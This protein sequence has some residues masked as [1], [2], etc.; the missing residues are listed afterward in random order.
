MTGHHAILGSDHLHFRDGDDNTKIKITATTNI[1]T[2]SGTGDTII[3]DGIGTPT[4]DN[5]VA[6]KSYVDSVAEGLN[7]LGAVK[8]ATTSNLNYTYDN[9][10]ATLTNG[11]TG[12]VSIDGIAL[13]LN[14]R[15]LVKDQTTAAQNG[16]YKVTT[17]GADA[18]GDNDAV[19]LVLTRSSDMTTGD[20]AASD[21]T[22]V[23]QG[24]VNFDAGFVCTS[25][26][27]SDTVGT[28][29]LTFTQFSGAGSI[30]AGT[31]LSKSGNTINLD[32]S[33]SLAGTLDVTGDT[34]VSTLDST[35]ATSLATGG[36]AVNIASSGAMTT[37]KGTLNVDEAVTLDSTLDVTGETKLANII[38]SDNHGGGVQRC[39]MKTGGQI[40]SQT[41]IKTD[42]LYIGDTVHP[43]LDKVDSD[44]YRV[45]IDGSG[46]IV[47]EGNLDVTGDTSVSTFDS[48]GATSLA[49]GGG[50]VNIAS[51]GVMTTVKGTL[52]VDEAVTLDSTLDVTGDTSVSTLDSSGATSLATGG[53]VVNIASSGVM[54]TVKG[55][56]NV[57]EAVTLDSTL[58]V[59]GDTSVSTLDSSGATSLA[60]S[61]GA[62]NI[63][64]TGAMTTVKGTLNVDEAVTLDSTLD[65]TGDTSVST[66]DS[67]EQLH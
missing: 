25:N 7:V 4:D 65:V 44:Y 20:S 47:T 19:A 51:S 52:N 18:D 50:V 42:T 54:T 38:V 59:T 60:T 22:F 10:S 39:Y 33:I 35:G 1:M 24:T 32:D 66:L 6:S 58:D 14:D 17:A 61:S 43:D 67:S 28:N 40:Y 12:E 63:A 64:S 26:S 23:E 37:V 11:S 16:I 30:T 5:H 8:V 2:F 56:L 29:D 13:V 9:D 21:F 15:V 3:I 45:K 49:T 62:V 46:H 53:G 36:G 27:G 57:D 41:S 31:N 34:S 48:S 55:T